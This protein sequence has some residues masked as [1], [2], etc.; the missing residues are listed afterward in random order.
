KR[1]LRGSQ[2]SGDLVTSPTA[3]TLHFNEVI[4]GG[5]MQIDEVVAGARRRAVALYQGMT[6]GIHDRDPR[7][8]LG[9]L[10][11]YHQLPAAVRQDAVIRRLERSDRL[12]EGRSERQGDSLECAGKQRPRFEPPQA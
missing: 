8:K 11:H 3:K 7:R 2:E 6:L 10:E 5:D 12:C 9:R 1:R 4:P